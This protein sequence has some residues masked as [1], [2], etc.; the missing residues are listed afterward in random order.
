[1]RGNISKVVQIWTGGGGVEIGLRNLSL[2][3]D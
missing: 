1:M 3:V 2:G